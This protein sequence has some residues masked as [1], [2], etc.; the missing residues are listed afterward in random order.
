[1]KACVLLFA[2]L[3]GQAFA[4]SLATVYLEDKNTRTI[5]ADAEVSDD[6]RGQVFDFYLTD[7]AAT[8]ELA[9]GTVAKGRLAV[10]SYVDAQPYDT[11][12]NVKPLLEV[13]GQG[14]TCKGTK[15]EFQVLELDYSS[16]KL[17]KLAVDFIQ[18]CKD[19]SKLSGALRF[20]SA[21][22]IQKP[23]VVA[24]VG[25]TPAP[26]PGTPVVLSIRS[27]AGEYIGQGNAIDYTE[28]DGSFTAQILTDGVE[29]QYP[30]AEMW[31]FQFMAIT[32]QGLKVGHYA[33]ATRAPFNDDD[34]TPGISVSA[35]GRGCNKIAGSF[36]ILE[37]ETDASGIAVDK[38]AV[39]FEQSC[40]GG[41]PMRGSVR[42]NSKFPL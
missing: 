33:N 42:I 26:A 21:L 23:I 14:V 17:T 41:P 11:Q 7:T 18:T 22:P 31:D 27:P 29:V 16:G 28:N 1:M 20:N 10:G 12:S 30:G 2:L 40:D 19:G 9:F 24:P 15:G 37:Y 34:G 39:D 6:A 35:D 13:S 36:D 25:T 4:S 38:L 32:G 3:S 5:I 8:Y